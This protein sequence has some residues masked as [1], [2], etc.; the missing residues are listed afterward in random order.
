[1]ALPKQ[2][3]VVSLDPRSLSD[4]LEDI[5]RVARATGTEALAT[6]LVA[7][8]QA[9]IEA[10]VATAAGAAKRPRVLHLE[11]VEPLMCGGHWIPEMVEL[12][13][14]VNCFG[15]KDTGSFRLEWPAVVASQPEVIIVMP[16]GFNVERASQDVPLLAAQ[17][18]WSTLPA[19][20][21]G[22]V[23][24]IDAGAYTSRSGPRL[25]QGLEIFAEMI[26]PEL[27]SGLIPPGG[28]VRLEGSDHKSLKKDSA[29]LHSA[30]C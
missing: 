20:Q 30:R 22:R 8:L 28:G 17:A 21:Q 9:R 14:G 19:V 1:M 15:Q 18:G 13:G 27:F 26:H 7:A 23:Y 16:C 25:V 4:V 24:V 29:S 5:N 11:W 6:A 3:A 10:V 2:P 12:A